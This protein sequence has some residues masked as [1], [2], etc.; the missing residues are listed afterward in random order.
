[1]NNPSITKILEICIPKLEFLSGEYRQRF[2]SEID[3]LKKWILFLNKDIATDLLRQR[4]ELVPSNKSGSVILFLLDISSIDP[5]MG[6]IPPQKQKYGKADPPDIDIDFHPEVRDKVKDYLTEKYGQEH[7]CNVGTLGTYKTKNVIL[8]V[9]RALGLDVREAMTV[10]KGLDKEIGDGDDEVAI[11][12][13]GFNEICSSQPDLKAY[14]EKHEEVAVHADALRYQAKNYGTH[15]GGFI[16]SSDKLLEKIPVFRD[17]EGKVVSAWSESGS[18]QELSGIGYIKFDMLSVKNV[19]VIADCIKHI[20]KNRGL[21]LRREDIP[22]DDKEAIKMGAKGELLGI[23]QF[24]NPYTKRVSDKVGVDCLA[25]IAAITSLIRPG[26]KDVGLDLEYAERKNGKK[27][28]SNAIVDRV[29]KDTYGILTYQEQLVLIAVEMAGFT[30]LEGNALRKATA[31]KKVDLMLSLKEKFINGAIEKSVKTGIMSEESVLRFWEMIESTAKYSFCKSHAYGYSAMSTA[32]FWLRHHYFAEFM[33]ALLQH[34]TTQKEKFG[35]TI[36]D[37]YI[38][39]AAANGVEVSPP[40]INDS[41]VEFSVRGNRILFGLGHIKNVGNSAE[42][43]IARRPYRDLDDFYSRCQVKVG[44]GYRKPNTRV[45][46]SL[47]YAG[48]FDRFGNREDVMKRY[49]GLSGRSQ[50]VALQPPVLSMQRMRATYPLSKPC[51][52]T[53]RVTEQTVDPLFVIT[54]KT[55]ERLK[56]IRELEYTDVLDYKGLPD[57]S[58]KVLAEKE[59]E[60][61]GIMLSGNLN[62]RFRKEIQEVKNFCAIGNLSCDKRVNVKTL[63]KI[64]SIKSVVFKSG[65]KGLKVAITDGTADFD[66]FVFSS[67]MEEFKNIFLLNDIG[68]LPL[69][70]FGDDEKTDIRFFNDRD[71]GLILERL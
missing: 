29:L 20:K 51:R 47:I 53:L 1:M 38:R 35:K 48:V 30:P 40:D 68:L 62:A 42:D 8:D 24:E 43:I 44:S 7:V 31:K 66:F 26:P 52:G 46:E 67:A 54:P 2:D 4:G 22:I 55:G 33:T 21:D 5:V 37:K 12:K 23:F 56:A 60:M 45:V 14:F 11:D 9:A 36:F 27:Y 16:I 41:D 58:V 69:K 10:T 65:N 50:G 18:S 34:S 32:Q 39:F 15:A 28:E 13:A 64:T 19:A 61:L 17:K 57:L 6:K 49:Y 3:D 63:G 25:D 70:S 71:S 59:Q